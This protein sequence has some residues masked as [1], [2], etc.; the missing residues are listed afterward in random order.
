MLNWYTTGEPVTGVYVIVALI[1]LG[2]TFFL[3]NYLVSIAGDVSKDQIQKY[4]NIYE[5]QA[6]IDAA[7]AEVAPTDD[8]VNPE[9]KE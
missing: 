4:K 9:V 1:F 8:E 5:A 3:L 7:N 6:A 2:F